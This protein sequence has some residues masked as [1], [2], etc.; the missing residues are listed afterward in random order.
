MKPTAVRHRTQA[1]SID[2]TSGMEQLS[3][4]RFRRKI[5]IKIPK[6]P[7]EIGNRDKE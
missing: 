7:R 5:E 2:G 3:G 6:I 4:S 1:G